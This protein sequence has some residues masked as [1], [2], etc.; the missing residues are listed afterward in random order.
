M[1][2]FWQLLSDI[3]RSS[4]KLS[5]ISNEIWIWFTFHDMY[6]KNDIVARNKFERIIQTDI[7]LKVVS[8]KHSHVKSN[9]RLSKLRKENNFCQIS[10]I[11]VYWVEFKT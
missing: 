4:M 11:F 7:R 1:I 5:L 6:Y 9:H 10:S 8:E 3:I 2:I